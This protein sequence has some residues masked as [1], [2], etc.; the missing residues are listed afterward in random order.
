MS[1]LNDWYMRRIYFIAGLV[2][3]C[4]GLSAQHRESEDILK[5]LQ[6]NDEMLNILIDTRAD[7]QSQFQGSDLDNVGFR[8]QT[9]RIWL[10]GEIIPGIR[11]RVRHR[12]NK[13]QSPLVRDNYSSAT[14][15]AWLAF[16][17]HKAWTIT[18][19]KQS[20]QLGTFEYDYNGADIYLS[21]M[22]NGDIDLYKTGVD[23][24][25]KVAGQ[26]FHLQVVNS[27]A[28]QFAS[29]EYK[30]K[31]FTANFLWAGA[32]FDNKLKT[33]WGYGLMQHDKSKFYSWLTLGVQL[34]VRKFVA[35]I[36]YYLGDRNMD[37]GSIVDNS[38]LGLRF[39]RDQ[40]AALNLRY[41]PDKW[42]FSVKGVWNLRY[43]KD[44]DRDAYDGLGAQA[45]AEYYPFTKELVK[46][47]RFH[48][49]Y[50]YS[51]TDFK[52]QFATLANKDVHTLLVGTR[53]LFKAK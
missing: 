18:V 37:Y 25:Y 42:H 52:G 40:S 49:A 14:D 3:L 28:P 20:M 46:D 11:Y 23:V 26:T 27:D 12:F 15:H 13:P 7:L 5:K 1:A 9:F 32:L 31:A 4:F 44:D 2:F 8:G 36:D 24:A 43:D 41:C 6:W 51:S 34:N 38:E 35:E 21:T 17:I 33:R 22:V 29:E 19:G 48:I 53:W 10:A 39:V 50:V 30:N 16:D 47:L 45:A